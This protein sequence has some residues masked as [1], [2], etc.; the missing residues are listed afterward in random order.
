VKYALRRLALTPLLLVF[1]TLVTYGGMRS[2]GT[3]EEIVRGLL[4]LTATPETEKQLIAELSLDKSVPAGYLSWVSKAV[5]GDFGTSYF[6]RE[7][8]TKILRQTFP[9]SLQLMVMAILLALAIAMPLAIYSAYRP[10]SR[11]DKF[12]T[13]ASFGALALPGFVISI[14]LLFFVALGTKIAGITIIPSG[15]FPT[16]NHVPLTENPI[17]SI[18]HLFLPALSLAIGLL[19]NYLRTLR[20]DMLNT[21]QEDYITL[22]KSKGLKDNYIL[23]R[24]ALRPSS[25]TLLTVAGITVGTLI[26]N[27]LIVEQVFTINGVGSAIVRALLGRDIPLVLGGVSAITMVFV[28]AT[29]AVDLLYGVLDPRVR[30]ARSIA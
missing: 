5:R 11:L 7:P 18:W 30:A 4:G 16:G 3:K 8:V 20:T 22:A 1:V 6:S 14:L 19:A 13:G 24:H 15:L 17:K 2:I 23:L 21:L 27:A 12:V 10:G 28:L 29:T 26:G 9:A 25:F